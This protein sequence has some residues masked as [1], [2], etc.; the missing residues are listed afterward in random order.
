MPVKV[1]PLEKIKLL[2]KM[3]HKGF[4]AARIAREMSQIYG[5]RISRNAIIGKVS[6]I[7]DKNRSLTLARAVTRTEGAAVH[8]VSKPEKR[9]P[10]PRLVV[11][12]PPLLTVPQALA[13]IK[14]DD[15]EPAPIEMDDFFGVALPPDKGRC[16]WVHG[17]PNEHDHT[18]CNHPALKLGD[19]TFSNYC[20]YHSA[21]AY[22]PTVA[23][24]DYLDK[25]ASWDI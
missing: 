24:K 1:W 23:S 19:Q 6:R 9:S 12:A 13:G 2:K 14:L 8:M 20:A 4:S 25:A 15:A 21:K 22:R 5:E 11:V 18:Y 7:Y 17:D 16:L 3:C 10:R